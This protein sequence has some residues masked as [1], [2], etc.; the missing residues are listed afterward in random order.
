MATE[1]PEDDHAPASASDIL[2]PDPSRADL[3]DR[4]HIHPEPDEPTADG[5]TVESGAPGPEQRVSETSASEKLHNRGLAEFYAMRLTWSRWLIGWVTGLIAFQIILTGAIGTGALDFAGHETFLNL[6]VGQN[7]VQ[8]VAL[9]MIVVRF[10]H[11]R[12][13]DDNPL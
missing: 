9:A 4:T 2:P 3:M 13:K 5:G 11:S 7:F 10:L 6:T 12:G 8:V 1:P